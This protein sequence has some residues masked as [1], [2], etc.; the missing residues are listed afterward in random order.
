[1]ASKNLNLTLAC[2]LAAML[3]VSGCGNSSSNPTQPPVDTTPPVLPSGLNVDFAPRHQVATITWQ[4]N[5]TDLDLAGY[6][7]YRG[8]YDL[9]PVAL[10][11]APQ[12]ATYY[13]DDD[14][15]G[16]G[17]VLTYYIHAVDTSGNASAAATITLTLENDDDP[18]QEA[19]TQF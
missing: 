17:R 1:M 11:A 14:I 5:A 18:I 9:S 6:L 2:L 4:A 13:V 10:V 19:P 12:A 8:S 3:I 16:H 7:V 15:E